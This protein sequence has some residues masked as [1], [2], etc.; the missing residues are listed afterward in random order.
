MR[1]SLVDLSNCFLILGVNK[2]NEGQQHGI[3]AQGSVFSGAGL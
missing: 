1:G 3:D 2:F